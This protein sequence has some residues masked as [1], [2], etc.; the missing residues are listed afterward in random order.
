MGLMDILV[1]PS[2][3]EAIGRVLLEAQ[4]LGVAVIATKAGGIPDII[5]DGVTG[6]LIPPENTE[7][8]VEAILDLS[9]DQAKRQ[10]FSEKGKQWVRNNFSI[11]VMINNLAEFYK[12]EVSK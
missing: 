7:A 2:L 8:L 5:C 4:G 12:E 11:E 1:Q 10:R 9:D 3:N 6:M